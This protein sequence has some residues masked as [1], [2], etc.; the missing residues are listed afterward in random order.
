MMKVKDLIAILEKLPPELPIVTLNNAEVRV[1]L[2][3]DD[4]LQRNV[5]YYSESREWLKGD[6]VEIW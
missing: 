2:E 6:V 3:E 1:E 5:S 4:L